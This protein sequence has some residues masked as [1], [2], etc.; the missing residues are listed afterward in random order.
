MKIIFTV[1][2]QDFVRFFVKYNNGT[3]KM[4]GSYVSYNFPL[5]STSLDTNIVRKKIIKS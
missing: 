2:K 5:N 4:F 1:P 3:E